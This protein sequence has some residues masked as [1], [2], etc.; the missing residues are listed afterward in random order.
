MSRKKGLGEMKKNGENR[1]PLLFFPVDCIKA[2]YCYGDRS[3]QKKLESVSLK[4]SKHF[5]LH[6]MMSL[7]KLYFRRKIEPSD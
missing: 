6:K 2:T 4:Y 3:Y 1:A 7:H 5:L